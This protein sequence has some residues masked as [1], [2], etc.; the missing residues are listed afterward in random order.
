MTAVADK[1]AITAIVPARGGSRGLPGK[2]LLE[3]NGEPLVARAA[4][5]AA[6]SDRVDRVIVSSDDQ[7]ILD[8]V[9]GLSGVQTDRRPAELA[10][11]E[12]RTV[13][14]VIELTDRLGVSS[15]AVLLLQPTS[16]LRTRAD[17][18]G[19]LD[20][21][22]ATDAPAVVSIV[23]HD[24]PRPEKLQR[25][26]DG[27]VEPY[28]GAGFEG[29]RQ[30]LPDVY[31][32]NGAFYLVDLAVLRRTRSFLPPGTLAHEMP[33]ERSINIDGPVDWQVLTAML[34]AGHWRAE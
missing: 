8:A 7:A 19:V 34:A 30:E 9:A 20:A 17:L 24:E 16:P 23:R 4:R 29:P 12:A 31:A 13:D 3:L 33:A 10:T 14:V 11:D 22:M 26:V 21:F 32:L 1:G 28:L 25:L 27:R 5:L 2:N 6:E 18:D 15:G